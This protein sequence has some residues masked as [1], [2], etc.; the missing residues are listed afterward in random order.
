MD[1]DS[2]LLH[3]CPISRKYLKGWRDSGSVVFT[4]DIVEFIRKYNLIVIRQINGSPYEVLTV[5]EALNIHSYNKR[6]ITMFDSRVW[7]VNNHNIF[8]VS[9]DKEI[10]VLFKLS[11]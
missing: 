10:I 9:G 4:D 5:D 7:T 2:N 11:F 3:S 8:N 6:Y 1:S